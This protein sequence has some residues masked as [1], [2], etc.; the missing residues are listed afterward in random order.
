MSTAECYPDKAPEANE[1]LDILSHHLRREIIYF[2]E[3]SV[4]GDTT[5]LDE[6]SDHIVSRIPESDRA[7]LATKLLHLHLP[8]LRDGGWLEFDRRSGSIRYHGHESA[9]ELLTDVLGIF[10]E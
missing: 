8:K 2:F 7:H 9:T 6:L 1:V 5:N 10:A 4:E 3:K